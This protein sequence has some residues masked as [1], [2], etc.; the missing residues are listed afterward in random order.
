MKVKK[1]KKG[2]LLLVL[3]VGALSCTNKQLVET[4]SER[5][6]HIEEYLK[7]NKPSRAAE[8]YKSLEKEA[9]AWLEGQQLE[10]Q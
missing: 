5:L 3:G 2:L 4:N 7:A 6:D 9:E 10:Q 8:E 1:M